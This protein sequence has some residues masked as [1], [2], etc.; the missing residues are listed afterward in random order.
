MCIQNVPEAYCNNWLWNCKKKH[1]KIKWNLF[2][3]LFPLIM[4]E[5]VGASRN[6]SKVRSQKSCGHVERELQ[7]SSTEKGLYPD[8]KLGRNSQPLSHRVVCQRIQP[9]KP[10]GY[11]D[12]GGVTHFIGQCSR[13]V[14]ARLHMLHVEKKLQESGKHADHVT[15]L[16][17][18]CLNPK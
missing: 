4:F 5:V 9:T 8:I 7:R 1:T 6:N 2:G 14:V 13:N 16:V 18:L 15:V 12:D 10:L 3:A 17:R 11:K